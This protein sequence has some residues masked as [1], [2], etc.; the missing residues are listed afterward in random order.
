MTDAAIN[1]LL[2]QFSSETAPQTET[3][4]QLWVVDENNP[5]LLSRLPVQPRNH[6]FIT[7]RQDVFCALQSLTD[8]AHLSDYDLAALSLQNL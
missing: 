2:E 3:A 5:A 8:N 1:A 6:H 7:N 4:N